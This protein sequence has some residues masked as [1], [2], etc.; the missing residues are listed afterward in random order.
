MFNRKNKAKQSLANVFITAGPAILFRWAAKPEWPVEYVS[1]NISQL[2]YSAED[3][4]KGRL[5]F[6]E[7]VHPD[8]LDQVGQEVET[9]TRQGKNT[10]S[11]TYRVVTRKGRIR[12][13][14]DRTV[15]ERNDDGGVTHYLGILIDI[16]NEKQAEFALQ[17]SEQKYRR[18]VESLGPHYI[19][20]T[21]NTAGDYT[22][23]SPSIESIL[24]YTREEFIPYNYEEF[25]TDHPINKL[26]IQYTERCVAGEKLP[27]YEMEVRHRD[28][29]TRRLEVT[30]APLFN[31]QGDV[32][33][34]EGIARDITENK[35]AEQ[36]LKVSEEQFRALVETM[37]DFVWEVDRNGVYTYCSPQIKK[38]LDI[39]PG[40]MLGKTPF[41]FMPPKEAEYIAG[42][43][44]AIVENREPF[45]ALENT[46]LHQDGHVVVMET[47]GVP[48]FDAEGHL[49][50]YR[51][52]DRDITLRKQ[53]EQKIKEQSV[54]LQSVIDGVQDAIMVIGTD[55]TVHLMNKAASTLFDAKFIADTAHPKCYEVCHQRG[56]PCGDNENFCAMREVMESGKPATI[57]HHHTRRDGTQKHVELVATPLLNDAGSVCGVIE[58]SRD[59]TGHLSVQQMLKEQK[60][61]LEH[62]A[63]HDILTGLPNR[64]LF[65]NRLDQSVRRAHRTGEKLAVLFIDLD[66]FKQ[67]NDSMGHALGDA[68]LKHVSRRLQACTRE[69]DTLARLGGDEFTVIMESL[70]LLQH[71][72]VLA[73]KMLR[74]LQ[75]PITVEGHEFYITVSIG[76]SLYPQDGN[77]AEILL[78]NADTAM[79]KAKD[80]GRNSV[81]FYT[82]AMTER[83]FERIL[84]ETH[85]HRAVENEQL[86]IYYQPQV[87]LGTGNL[88]GMEALVRWQHPEMG[89]VSPAKFIPLAE[90]TGLITS[91]GEWVFRA[92]CTRISEWYEAGLNPGRIA[93]NV[94]GKQLQNEAFLTMVQGVLHETGCRPEWLELEITE[95]FIM[96]QQECSIGV[97]RKLRDLGIE[98]AIDDFGTGYSSLAHLK[99]LPVSKL[100]IDGSFVRDIPKD[101]NDKGIARAVIALGKSLG[102]RVI[103]EGVETGE[104]KTFLSREG[105]DEGQGY[106]Y[107]HPM[108]HEKMAGVLKDWPRKAE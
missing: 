67:I 88:I 26:A 46:N 44:S 107:G 65:L 105:C 89:L 75:A 103:A 36:A 64:M 73:Q 94:T 74:A 58:T 80:E 39:E 21:H 52:I 53:A 83:A 25:L 40:E 70:H 31:E 47:N 38:I 3:L 55:Y 34:V 48:F 51:G 29:S 98:L 19:F 37:E 85:L 66:Q 30:E 5:K 90:D 35:K 15:V 12:W 20:Y 11:Q 68:V 50:G 59:I 63:H 69:D 106:F 61:S 102:L 76:I 56:N 24:G 96:K 62:L 97:L 9:Y 17:Q 101:A 108:P 91:L 93:I 84:M 72:T 41:D 49:A 8:D 54:F 1:E 16:T 71:A 18:L 60:A 78:R 4:V 86:V 27:P 2:G 81:Q 42:L 99:Q 79:Y 14:E 6:A 7:I 87:N 33:A 32:V 23:L 13:V 45:T 92:A 77:D 10:F 22:Y 57:V 28:G 82:E 95:N 100:K 104:Q 43:F